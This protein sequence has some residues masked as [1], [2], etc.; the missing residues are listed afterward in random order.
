MDT[1]DKIIQL[2][3][4]KHLNDIVFERELGLARSTVSDWK[5]GKTKSYK[6]H[7]KEIAEYFDVSVDFLLDTKKAPTN[8]DEVLDGVGTI[9][10][11]ELE[12]IKKYRFLDERGKKAVYNTMEYEYNQV[13]KGKLSN[14]PHDVEIGKMG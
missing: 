9:K 13:K 12:L 7:I 3:T 1:V 5:K 11:E 14:S 4:E 8:I 2:I 6:K 10:I